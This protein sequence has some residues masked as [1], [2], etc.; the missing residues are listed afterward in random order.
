MRKTLAVLLAAATFAIMGCEEE[1]EKKE[2]QPATAHQTN[3]AGIDQYFKIGRADTAIALKFVKDNSSSSY[4]LEFRTKNGAGIIITTTPNID[5]TR[6]G[7][8]VYNGI[9]FNVLYKPSNRTVT[10]DANGSGLI[11]DLDE[12][13]YLVIKDETK[14]I[15]LG[16]HAV[17]V[18]QNKQEEIVTFET[19]SPVT[20]IFRRSTFGTTVP[21]QL[22]LQPSGSLA[23][24]LTL[25]G[26]NYGVVVQQNGYVRMDLNGDGTIEN[27]NPTGYPLRPHGNRETFNLNQQKSLTVNSTQ[28]DIT[29][30]DIFSDYKA[31]LNVA[32]QTLN[33]CERGASYSLTDGSLLEI[34]DVA[35]QTSVNSAKVTLNIR[36]N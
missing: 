22:S 23:G 33:F 19:Y 5:G 3:V 30:T 16:Q 34:V 28:Y 25:D 11:D 20:A 36:R 17:I 10:L 13:E 27:H 4:D 14:N 12:L 2:E 26:R 6:S 31:S 15:S 1:K 29:V 7:E 9:T 35:P 21:V 8:L 32:G 18:D 24:D